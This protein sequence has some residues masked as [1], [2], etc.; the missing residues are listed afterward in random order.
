[1]KQ[2]ERKSI[3]IFSLNASAKYIS[4]SMLSCVSKVSIRKIILGQLSIKDWRQLAEASG[5]LAESNIFINDITSISI[6]E[7]YKRCIQLRNSH[8]LDMVIV[9][10]LDFMRRYQKKATNGHNR[11][12]ILSTLR[13]LANELN[14]PII[15][16]LN[17][18]DFVERKRSFWPCN[19]D[20]PG[21]STIERYADIIMILHR[22]EIY[23]PTLENEGLAEIRVFRQNNGNG[24]KVR[25]HFLGETQRFVN[26]D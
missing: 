11:G 24:G 14:V 19:L 7:L 12:T 6:E 21:V 17:V 23:S 2:N 4:M 8:A 26:I 25:L 3:A 13:V 16:S 1:M 5:A 18:K 10:S 22:P 20:L 15:V 9:D